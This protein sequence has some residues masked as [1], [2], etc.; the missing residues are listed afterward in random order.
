MACWDTIPRF[1]QVQY[2]ITVPWGHMEE[3]IQSFN[4]T[5]ELDLNPDFQRGHVWTEEQ[6]INFVEYAL[7]RPQSGL[8]IF[9][10]HPYWM[11]F[12][13]EG[14]MVLVDGKQRLEAVRRFMKNEIKA[15]GH[16]CK[17]YTEFSPGHPCKSRLPTDYYF[18]FNVMKIPDR[19]GVLKWY[20]DF[21][22]GGT[23][24]SK[25]EIDRV[26]K[27]LEKERG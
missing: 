5:G 8:D 2:R 9:W 6:Q 27:L 21:N 15:H 20:I 4:E 14:T 10:N 12:S 26:K 19:A 25:K 11:D 22:A 16:Y 18:Y 17:E 1:P 24:H 13:E 7:M 3:Q 23:P